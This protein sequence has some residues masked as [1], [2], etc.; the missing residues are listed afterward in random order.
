M[1]HELLSSCLSIVY[2]LFLQ[3]K[4]YI[5]AVEH[6][7]I[8]IHLLI[9]SLSFHSY[10][11]SPCLILNSGGHNL[12]TIILL[13]LFQSIIHAF[14][15]NE[16]NVSKTNFLCIIAINKLINPFLFFVDPVNAPTCPPDHFKC[17]D[18]RCVKNEWLCDGDN[19][20]GD[21]SDELNCRKLL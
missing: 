9:M 4:C 15:L 3:L 17:N 19:D 8:V 12:Y 1:N 16:N 20:C 2:I 6:C 7:S 11:L 18:E 5:F 21:N 14:I 13:E 10:S